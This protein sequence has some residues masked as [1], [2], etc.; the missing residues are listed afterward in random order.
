M[1]T[2]K[3]HLVRKGSD[4]GLT[5]C[6]FRGEK[7]IGHAQGDEHTTILER[8]FGKDVVSNEQIEEVLRDGPAWNR[9]NSSLL[10]DLVPS[11]PL[12]AALHALGADVALR[13]GVWDE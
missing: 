9:L 1:A 4:F 6:D 5:S 2:I 7:F 8:E 11:G 13:I 3:V 10:R 12:K